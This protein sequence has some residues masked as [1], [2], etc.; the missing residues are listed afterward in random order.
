[1][2]T[3]QHIASIAV[4]PSAEPMQLPVDFVMGENTVASMRTLTEQLPDPLAKELVL[5]SLR[6]GL[7]TEDLL[8]IALARAVQLWT[9]YDRVTVEHLNHGRR[10]GSSGVDA[11]RS[12]G[13]FTTGVPVSLDMHGSVDPGALVE[14]LH[15]HAHRADGGGLAYWA[16][17]AR[18]LESGMDWQPRA[19]CLN[20]LGG[21]RIQ[22][23]HGLLKRITPPPTWTGSIPSSA[24]RPYVIELQ[25]AFADDTL[26]CAWR[27]SA[28]LHREE[29]LRSLACHFRESLLPLVE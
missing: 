27:Y 29:T 17:T 8:L 6:L 5:A 14:Q 2:L 7:M 1:M 16:Q 24:R 25:T 11:S 13:W 3:E 18:A 20:H 28:H 22:T 26:H 15:N 19:I 4:A 23:A 21:P 10:L 12:V 9:G